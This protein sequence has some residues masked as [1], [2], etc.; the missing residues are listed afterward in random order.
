MTTKKLSNMVYSND[1]DDATTCEPSAAPAITAKAKPTNMETKPASL[2]DDIFYPFSTDGV[3]VTLVVDGST[4]DLSS[5][6]GDIILASRPHTPQSDGSES[7]F[8]LVSCPPCPADKPYRDIEDL[9]NDI[10]SAAHTPK[11]SN[12]PHYIEELSME[13]EDA[14]T[15]KRFSTLS[16]LTHYLE[17]GACEGD[18]GPHFFVCFKSIELLSAT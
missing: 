1:A 10:A 8:S 14:K 5:S 3:A 2:A 13:F 15:I 12:C 17:S 16:G 18:D 4:G 7:D 9:Q 6:S 11:T